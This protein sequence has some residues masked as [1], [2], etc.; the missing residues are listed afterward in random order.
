VDTVDTDRLE[1][2]VARLGYLGQL[3]GRPSY[4]IFPPAS[5]RKPEGPPIEYHEMRI[6]DCRAV[7]DDLDLDRHG[8]AVRSYAS[9]GKNFFDEELVRTRYYPEIAAI[10]KEA[11]GAADVFVF[12]HNVRS[13]EGAAKGKAGVRAPVDG[14]H[15][16]YTE[17]SG[18]RRTRELLEAC[19]PSDLSHHRVALIN[20]WRPIRGPV[21]DLPLAICDAQSVSAVDFVETDI[22]HFGEDDTTHPRHT[23]QIYSVHYNPEHRWFYVPDMQ[24]H[25][26][27][28]FKCYDSLKEGVARFTPHTG[29]SNPECPPEF[30]PRESIEARTIVIY[31]RF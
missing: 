1:F 31:P 15:D 3:E 8:F 25:E 13:V 22:E 4:R 23:G 18:E 19:C 30:I 9:A 20:A 27:L 17:M 5:G 26:V 7:A 10:V 28:L 21:E 6:Y 2:V 11:T 12:D 14:V 29:F 16:D 24:P